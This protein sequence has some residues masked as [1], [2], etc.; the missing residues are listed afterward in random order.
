MA[1]GGY[2]LDP[3]VVMRAL[4]ALCDGLWLGVAADG[5]GHPGRITPEEAH[6]IVD[7]ALTAFFP[8]HFPARRV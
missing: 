8:R 4:E 7:T 1:E 5:A 2:A 6:R 3:T